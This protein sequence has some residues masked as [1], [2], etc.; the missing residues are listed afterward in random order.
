MQTARRTAK[1]NAA[2]ADGEEERR[3]RE[4]IAR[5]DEEDKSA[6]VYGQEIGE[7]IRCKD[8]KYYKKKYGVCN[9]YITFNPGKKDDDFCSMAERKGK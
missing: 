1:N 4:I 3:M 6:F 7:I 9:A 2:E 8:C 5:F